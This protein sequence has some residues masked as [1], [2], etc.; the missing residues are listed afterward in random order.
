M[1][2]VALILGAVGAVT[3]AGASKTASQFERQQYEEEAESNRVAA[4]QDENLRRRNLAA[5]LAA[6][7]V[8]F[9]ANGLDPNSPMAQALREETVG[10]AEDDIATAQ[11][12]FSNRRRRNQLA[13]AQADAAGDAAEVGG[14]MNAAGGLLQFGSKW[15][16][17]G[18]VPK[19]PSGG[20]T[21]L[22]NYGMTKQGAY[23]G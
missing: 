20:N 18:S 21:G 3:S 22:A 11:L 19:S 1:G 15:A 7:E 8:Y 12:N 2:E 16:S 14:W 13:A 5:T 17:T 6:Q 10:L 23:Y 9:G 4:V